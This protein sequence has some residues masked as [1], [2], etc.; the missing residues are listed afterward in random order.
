MAPRPKPSLSGLGMVARNV[1]WH[2]FCSDDMVS[3]ES[4]DLLG[5]FLEF[6]CQNWLFGVSI[7]VLF[8][9]CLS[10]LK[11]SEQIVASIDCIHLLGWRLC[12]LFQFLKLRW[13]VELKHSLESYMKPM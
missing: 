13:V 6:L 11:L 3:V 9:F 5:E 7:L 10:L 1:V 8:Q 4:V 12:G 2:S